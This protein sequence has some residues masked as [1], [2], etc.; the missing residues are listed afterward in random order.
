MK[1]KLKLNSNDIYYEISYPEIR[2]MFELVNL[3]RNDVFFDLGCGKG[4]AVR[5]AVRERKVK[6]A[7]G[8][9]KYYHYFDCARR[10]AIRALSKN[11]LSKI[12]YWLGDMENKDWSHDDGSYVFDYKKATVAYDSLIERKED[13]AFYK[14]RL[15][16]RVKLIKKDLPLVGYKPAAVSR[17]SNTCWFFLMRFPLVKVRNKNEWASYVLGKKGCTMKSVY[18]YYRQQL[19][20]HFRKD[21]KREELVRLSLRDLSLVIKDRFG[22]KN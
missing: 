22:I 15:S 12:E 3:R 16:K 20:K 4:L 14:K 7:V 11:Q 17:K 8:V 18:G 5:M 1:V 13:I 2:N 9:E 10:N 19:R 6:R 21:S